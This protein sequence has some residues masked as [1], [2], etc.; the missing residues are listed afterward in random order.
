MDPS[1]RYEIVDTIATGDFA[2]VYRARDREL[3]REVAI[4]Q[5]HQQF[6]ADQQQLARY[7]HEA[8]LLASLQ[9][10]NIL[11]IYDIVRPR[12]W[13]ILE[14]MR[15]NLK[16]MTQA[17]PLDL[18]FLRVGLVGCLGALQFLH[19]NGIIH[20]DVKPSNLLV[21]SRNRVVLGDFGLARRAASEEGSLLKG[22]T[23]YMAPELVSKGFGA[24]GP[25]SDLYSLGFSAYELMCGPQ[26][27][28]LF[29]TLSTLGR[30]KQIAWMMWHAAADQKLPEIGRVLEGVPEDLARVV[31]K[32][33]VKDQARRY[34]SARDVLGDLK[35][36]AMAVEASLGEDVEAQAAAAAEAKRKQR[37][38]IGAVIALAFSLMLCLALLW[39]A[40][41]ERFSGVVGNVDPDR[42][43]VELKLEDGSLKE[44]ELQ[45]ENSVVYINE[46]RRTAKDL[47]PGDEVKVKIV[48]G[49]AEVRA[50]RSISGVVAEVF[51]R[52]IELRLAD[53]TSKDVRLSPDAFEVFVNDEKKL[54]R[55]LQ[56]GDEVTVALVEGKVEIRA[57]R[58]VVDRGEIVALQVDHGRFTLGMGEGES[59]QE[60]VIEVLTD[61]PIQFNKNRGILEQPVKLADLK[62]GDRVVEVYHKKGEEDI[63]LATQLSV[64]RVVSFPGVLREVVLKRTG[65]TEGTLKV[66]PDGAGDTQPIE[67]PIAPGCKVTINNQNLIDNQIPKVND[68]LPGDRVT[69]SHDSQ[70]VAVDAHRE[71]HETGTV[72]KVHF[73]AKMLDVR[74]QGEDAPTPF[75]IPAE[76]PITLD[77]QTVKLTDL[78]DGDSVRVVHESL[79]KAVPPKAKEVVASRLGDR[80][81]WAILIAVQDYDDSSLRLNH[82]IGDAQVLRDVL[83]TR[84]RVP[85]D[86]AELELFKNASL[87]TLQQEIPAQLAKIGPEESVIVLFSGQAF[88]N[89]DGRVYLAP[90]SFHTGQMLT[91]GLRLQWLVDQLESCA[92]KEKLLLLDCSHQGTTA[93][94][95]RQPST[96][97]MIRTLDAPPGRSP[98]RTVTTIASCQAGQRGLLVEGTDRGRFAAALEKAYSGGADK[99]RDG[100]LETTELFEFLAGDMAAASQQLGNP[101]SPE[102]FSPDDRPPRLSEDAK[103]AI[104]KL[105]AILPTTSIDFLEAD[106]LYADAA[107]LAGKEVEPKLIYGMLLLRDIRLRDKALAHFEELK[108]AYPELVL[109]RQG[110]VW[111]QFERRSYPAGVDAL[112]ELVAGVPKPKK[113]G[114]PYPDPARQV[115]FWVGQLREFAGSG[116]DPLRW[117]TPQSLAAVDAAVE[118]HGG[119]AKTLY[120]QGR[121]YSAGVLDKYDR[122]LAAAPDDIT[123]ARLKVERRQLS[124]YAV[125]PF[126][127]AAKHILAGLDQ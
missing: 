37:L 59:R 110:I 3:G 115:F 62:V 66:A 21:D 42:Q 4:K 50:Y 49:V 84:Y 52:K 47:L 103:E 121:A 38:R 39:P 89:D 61:L 65:G 99:N 91:T 113:P 120:E 98:F 33:T 77:G 74:L 44:V 81:R 22:T 93:V 76:C 78:R 105:A 54:P 123:A 58:P 90:R 100:R 87:V 71:I 94:T 40:K 79:S 56:P 6:L 24:V 27:E 28:S 126:D 92:A 69:V 25:A 34:Q 64:E 70:A 11:T 68:L 55:F 111:V 96:A 101:Q 7:W 17:G 85:D 122:I 32:L 124:R 88:E 82:P 41:A 104:R 60:I 75:A 48:G 127:F 43:K 51:E 63:R 109:P 14:L 46:A 67:M 57:Y 97:E 116:P 19:G 118:E 119:E 72:D 29:P 83:T 36:D 80:S 10:P 8:Q 102:L 23:K 35:H 20:G 107:A 16:Q 12:G 18:D 1:S 5:I 9:H 53:G 112:G 86:Q 31:Q 114:E 73:D 30:D 15:G 108:S 125:F 106:R 13:L 45:S 117:P 95:A 2:V 26:F